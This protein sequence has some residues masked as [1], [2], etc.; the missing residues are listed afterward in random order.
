MRTS[1]TA[2]TE[3]ATLSH[4]ERRVPGALLAVRS[5]LGV[6]MLL[7]PEVKSQFVG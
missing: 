7:K 6:V 1:A 4:D 3:I 5:V 2:T